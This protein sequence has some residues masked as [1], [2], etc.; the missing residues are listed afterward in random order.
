MK[1]ISIIVLVS[2]AAAHAAAAQELTRTTVRASGSYAIGH[3][4]AGASLSSASTVTRSAASVFPYLGSVPAALRRLDVAHSAT[5]YAYLFGQRAEATALSGS[6]YAATGQW[7]TLTHL[8]TGQLRVMNYVPGPQAGC[9]VALRVAGQAI[10]TFTGQGSLS[11]SVSHEVTRTLFADQQRRFDLPLGSVT[12]DGSVTVE[13][14]FS[15]AVTTVLATDPRIDGYVS[16][17]GNVRGGFRASVDFI[18]SALT[19]DA[20]L[21]LGDTGARANAGYAGLIGIP[22]A[23]LALVLTPM[24][25]RADLLLR[26]G[27]GWLSRTFEYNL[28][29]WS[30]P[31][32]RV[33]HTLR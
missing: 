17:Y 4:N 31:E 7:T 30:A 33:S 12:V 25:V 24:S 6:C 14:G 9:N 8:Y 26:I 16:V 27:L 2:A 18:V 23:N 13:A 32:I 29:R 21:R 5:A 1:N 3:T 11:A 19:L 15:G 10:G 28:F 22:F 20:E